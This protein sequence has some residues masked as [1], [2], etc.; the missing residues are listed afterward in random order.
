[1]SSPQPVYRVPSRNVESLVGM[2]S[3][4]SP[5]TLA[6]ARK[7]VSRDKHVCRNTV[8]CGKL[9]GEKLYAYWDIMEATAGEEDENL[10]DHKGLPSTE[11]VT[12]TQDEEGHRCFSPTSRGLSS[13]GWSKTT[14]RRVAKERKADLRDFYIHNLSL[15]RWYHLGYVHEPG[16]D[17]CKATSERVLWLDAS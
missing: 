17:R 11:P 14:A 2:S 15:F 9:R 6:K 10:D 7:I 13:I 1:V 16:C 3:P 8:A 5:F 4:E 12:K